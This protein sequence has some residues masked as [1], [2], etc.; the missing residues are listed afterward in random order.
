MAGGKTRPVIQVEQ[1]ILSTDDPR[2]LIYTQIAHP[3]PPTFLAHRNHWI[4]VGVWRG[5]GDVVEL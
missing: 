4:T 5:N 2:I 1:H 3:L